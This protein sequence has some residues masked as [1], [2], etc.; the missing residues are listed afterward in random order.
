MTHSLNDFG[1]TALA[2]V[3]LPAGNPD[4]IEALHKAVDE[5]LVRLDTLYQAVIPLLE[6]LSTNPEK[7][8]IYWPN[9][10]ESVNKF[11]DK[12]LNIKNGKY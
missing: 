9:R 4:E 7:E 2:E 10:L 5:L 8:H 1:F 12:I 3:E 6:N 11:R